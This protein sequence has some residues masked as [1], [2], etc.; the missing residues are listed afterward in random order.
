MLIAIVKLLVKAFDVVFI[1][2]SWKNSSCSKSANDVGYWKTLIPY[3][4]IKSTNVLFDML[5]L[6]PNTFILSFNSSIQA[7]FNGPKH[8]TSK[9]CILSVTWGSR[10]K[11]VIFSSLA[12]WIDNLICVT[13][14]HHKLLIAVS[15]WLDCKIFQTIDETLAYSSKHYIIRYS[16]IVFGRADFR[17]H[18]DWKFLPVNITKGSIAM[19]EALQA[20]NTSDILT[21]CSWS[22]FIGYLPL[23]S[24]YFT[25]S[26]ICGEFWFI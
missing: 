5:S 3:L 1:P 14:D 9:G 8:E 17:F 25:S 24:N 16:Y 18:D 20:A 26:S 7:L 12:F 6:G 13:D 19:P 4:R 11:I 10:F 2:I 22:Y 21:A 15:P 23:W